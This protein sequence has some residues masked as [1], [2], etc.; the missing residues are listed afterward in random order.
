MTT[1]TETYDWFVAQYKFAGYKSLSQYATANGLQKST[2]SRYF[3]LERQI[4]SSTL[5][6]LAETLITT[7]ETILREIG[8]YNGR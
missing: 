1:S 8:A 3:H 4:P 5:V 7:P 6:I 2:L